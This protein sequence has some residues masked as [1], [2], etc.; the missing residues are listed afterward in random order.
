M[1]RS[2]K[3]KINKKADLPEIKP[4]KFPGDPD[5][6][7]SITRCP[8]CNAEIGGDGGTYSCPTHGVVTPIFGGFYER[9]VPQKGERTKGFGPKDTVVNPQV[10]VY[11]SKSKK[12]DKDIAK[13]DDSTVRDV[14][15]SDAIDQCLKP[16]KKNCKCDDIQDDVLASCKFLEIDG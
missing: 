9:K 10:P 2:K 7:K 11:A 8:H 14:F 3:K 12:K 16:S 13:N 6:A 1:E 5:P 4:L 15:V